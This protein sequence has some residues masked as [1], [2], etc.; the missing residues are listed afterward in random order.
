MTVANLVGRVLVLPLLLVRVYGV[1]APQSAAATDERKVAASSSAPILDWRYVESEDYRIYIANLRA[2]GCP[3]QTIR[4]IVTTDVISVFAGRR[5]EAFKTRY[6]NFQYWKSDPSETQARAALNAQRRA[7]DSEM[8]GVLQEL[9]GA[10]TP[11]PDITRE[12]QNAD[13]DFKL[14]FLAA[15]KL[16]QTK[17][18]LLEHDHTDQQAKQLSD[19]NCVT[20]DTNELQSILDAHEQERAALR[21]ILST[22][23]FVRVEMTASWTGENLRHAL[24]HFVP[25]EE[26]FRVI[27]AAWKER[28]EQ[29]AR[30]NAARAVDPDPGSKGV[31]AKIES[32]LTEERAKAFRDTWWK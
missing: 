4:D 17:A 10:D 3:A 20:E 18:I 21:D 19:G 24:V 31:K 13:L 6:Q 32:Q 28:D 14:G 9:L 1:E 12:W 7:L 23:E 11:L 25:T 5:N 29:L 26:E 22:D 30:I 15:D 16:A 27:F 8:N 2:I